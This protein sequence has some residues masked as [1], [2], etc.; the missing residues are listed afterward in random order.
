MIER[1]TEALE[2]QFLHAALEVDCPGC[3][4]PIWVTGAEIVA[5][6]AVLCPCC[7]VRAWVVDADGSFQNAARVVEQEINQALR[8]LWR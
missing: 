8:D 2:T 5:Q 7:R 4:Y 1:V 6:A 3:E